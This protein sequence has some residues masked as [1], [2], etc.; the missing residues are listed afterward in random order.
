MDAGGRSDL[1][2]RTIAGRYELKDV[3]GRGGMAT[4]YRAYQQALDRQVAVKIIASNLAHDPEFVERFRREARTV[5]RLRHPNI[6]TVHDFG[7]EDGLLFLVTELIG[8]GTLQSRMQEFRVA[9]RA[10]ELVAQ[11]GAALDFAHAQGVVHRDVKPLN[12]FLERR[13]EADQGDQAILADFGIA[14]ATAET[15][16]GGLTGTGLSIGTPEYMAPEQLTGEAVDGRADLYALAVIAYQLLTGR[17][18]IPRGGPHDTPLA[19]VM[20]KT[21]TPPPAPTTFNPHLPSA[22]DRVLLRALATEPRERFATAADF[23]GALRSALTARSNAVPPRNPAASFSPQRPV[24]EYPPAVGQSST[25]PLPPVASP[26]PPQRPPEAVPPTQRVA[27]PYQQPVPPVPQRAPEVRPV[28]AFGPAPQSLPAGGVPLV[29]A[30]SVAPNPPPPTAARRWWLPIAGILAVTL[31]AVIF[32]GVYG[33][34]LLARAGGGGAT[35]TATVRAVGTIG[36]IGGGASPTA[37]IGVSPTGTSAATT[38]AALPATPAQPTPTVAPTPTVTVAPTATATTAPPTATATVVPPT[39]TSVPPTNTPPPPP[40]PTATR[41]PS[42]TPSLPVATG[43]PTGT[44]LYSSDKEGVW[45]IY[46]LNPD[47]SGERRLTEL[48][49]NNYHGVWAPD[50]SL[51]AFVS[52]RDG[53]PEIYLMNPDGTGQR[54]LTTDQGQHASP[55]WGSDSRKVAYVL[56]TGGVEAVYYVDITTNARKGLIN[57]PAGWPAWSSKDDIA[58]TRSEGGY[59]TIYLSTVTGSASSKLPRPTAQSEDTPAF[60]P[61]GNFLAFAAGTKD[62]RQ[63]IVCTASGAPRTAITARGADNSNPVWSPDG[64]YI[65]YSSTASG[66]QQLVVMRNDGTEATTITTGPGKKWYLS[67][68]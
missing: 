23:V 32:A 59:V 66:T 10:I 13:G 5:A 53:N 21:Q 39:N 62:N 33:R 36:V 61:D 12:I 24:W 16:G 14:K 18:P 7:E 28:A 27:P 41:A 29:P 26:A 57:A 8:G 56:K 25:V 67:W 46:R 47:G 3:L 63:I 58:W 9:D 48:T 52:E 49:A 55:A 37:T 38:G 15:T 11:V 40:S 31:I 34:G 54:R 44:L 4:V 60:S 45:A 65:A 2:G 22:V 43:P 64:A 35:A 19:L 1:V 51:I 6:L 50:G 42:T 68:R 30:E 17:L 20:R